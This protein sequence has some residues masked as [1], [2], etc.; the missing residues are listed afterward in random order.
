MNLDAKLHWKEHRKK[1]FEEIRQRIKR[2]CW[3]LGP[4]S[5]FSIQQITL[6]QTNCQT[7]LDVRHTALE[8][9]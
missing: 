8:L 5:E 3:P 4:K 9:Y 1:K 6:I 7:Y 2:M